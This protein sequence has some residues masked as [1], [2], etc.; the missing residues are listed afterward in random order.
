MP[1]TAK[2][3]IEYVTLLEEAVAPKLELFRN[4]ARIKVCYGG[5]G[6]G[7]KS[8]SIAS[9]LVQRAQKE[10]IQILCT[11]EIQLSLEESV[12]RLI[13]QTVERLH[14]PGWI[15][16]REYIQSPRGSYFYFR[17]M[18]DM[19]AAAQI[20]GYEGVDIAWVEEGATVSTDSLDLL[21]PTIRSPKSEIWISFNREEEMDPV[22][23]RFVRHPRPDAIVVWLEPGKIDNPWWPPELQTEMEEDYKRDSDQAE[24]IWGGQPRKQGLK[25]VLSR[26]AIRGAMDRDIQAEGA[27]E[28]GVDV[29]RFGD[30]LT[31]M[32]KRHG[33]KVIDQKY[34]AGQD[35][36]RTAMEAWD[37]AGHDVSVPIKIDDGGLGGGST[38]RLNELGANVVP[39]NF[40]GEPHDKDLY[41]SVADEMWFT[42]PVDEADI[43][44]DPLLMQELAGRQYDYDTK[45]RRKIEA[46]KDF[47]KRIGRSPDRADALLLCYYPAHRYNVMVQGEGSAGELGL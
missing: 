25:A 1:L 32:Y 26:T 7:A 15:F 16:G 4:P 13:M 33:L 21:I 2:E 45:G 10:K 27:Y 23:E 43:P 38:D 18:K 19:R 47:K 40:G 36:Q 17:G 39:I 12:H 8:W 9:L 5:R 29:A 42:F 37:L 34:F 14:Y 28:I 41:T 3:E 20:K 22:Y 11:R 46:K 44:N 6:A 30:D 31:I 24:H 35:T